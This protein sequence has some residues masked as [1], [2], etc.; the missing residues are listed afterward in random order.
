MATWYSDHMASEPAVGPRPQPDLLDMLWR[1]A[2]NNVATVV[3]LVILA[4]TLALAAVVP[5]EP[6]GLSGATAEYWLATTASAYGSLGSG[7]RALGILDVFGSLWI[8]GLLALLAY[9]FL[10]RLAGQLRYTWRRRRRTFPRPPADLASQRVFL[11][12]RPDQVADMVDRSLKS[13]GYR[14][15][16]VLETAPHRS[17][18]Y[19]MRRP[20]A[21]VGPALA[22][23]GALL[24]LLALLFNSIGGWTVGQLPLAPGS[25]ASAGPGGGLELKLEGLVGSDA[26]PAATVTLTAADGRSRRAQVGYG[27]PAVWGNLWLVQRASGPALAVSAQDDQGHAIAMGTPSSGERAGSAAHVLFTATQ[28]EQVFTVPARNVAFRVV[29]YPALPE[30]GIPE[31]VFLVEAYRGGADPTPAL[32]QLVRGEASLTLDGVTYR[33]LAE[34]HAVL[35][36]GYAPGM[37][38]LALAVLLLLAGIVICLWPGSSEIWVGLAANDEGVQSLVRAAALVEADLERSRTVRAL[39]TAGRGEG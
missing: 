17:L 3:L 34:R 29:N 19:G 23:A 27:R 20:R 32:S 7:L 16:V 36:L 38:P 12:G 37:W 10:L 6:D 15:L 9:H 22:Y 39:E 28:T 13:A 5:Q 14:S 8:R 31:T 26:T 33:F 30:R 18:L 11:A 21:A 24:A 2:T 35:S 25:L 1:L 4:A